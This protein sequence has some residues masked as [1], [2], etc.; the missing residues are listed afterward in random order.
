MLKITRSI[1]RLFIFV[2]VFLVCLIGSI[3]G[4]GGGSAGTGTGEQLYS[5]TISNTQGSPVPH[6]TVTIEET[7]DSAQ[8]DPNGEFTIV[9]EPD[10]T[11]VTLLVETAKGTTKVPVAFL[12]G[13]SATSITIQIDEDSVSQNGSVA[14]LNAR[15]K[16]IGECDQA[17]ENTRPIRQ[18]NKLPAGKICTVRV[19][20]QSSRG[21]LIGRKYV[22]QEKSCD[23]QSSW[24][25]DGSGETDGSGISLFQFPF[26][27][28]YKTCLY[29]VLVPVDDAKISPLS[30]EIHTLTFQNQK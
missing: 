28:S 11:N 7:G 26:T 3:A 6:A 19:T 8:T 2:A 30:F 13:S 14:G 15:V 21:A 24:K 10:L 25:T 20:L 29:R 18:A 16:I 12:D 23:A 22:L 17:F 4:C 27:D 9:S 1:S 5:G